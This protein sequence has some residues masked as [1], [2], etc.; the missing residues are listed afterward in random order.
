MRLGSIEG[1][2]DEPVVRVDKGA[3]REEG[4]A[5]ARNAESIVDGFL[6]VVGNAYE[7]D[8]MY[9][10]FRDHEAPCPKLG[11]TRDAFRAHAAYLPSP[12]F[13]AL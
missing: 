11:P 13:T 7:L 3:H 2:C 9:G 1:V 12:S 10:I 5:N 4:R 8:E 6:L